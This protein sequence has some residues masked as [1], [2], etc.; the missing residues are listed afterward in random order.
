MA[1]TTYTDV[2]KFIPGNYDSVSKL[3]DAYITSNVIPSADD[4]IN[5]VLGDVYGLFND[6]TDSPATP[7]EI[8]QISN[9]IA[10]ATC[11]QIIGV[12]DALEARRDQYRT[13][14]SERLAALLS[15]GAQMRPQYVTSETLT[16]GDGSPYF[17][18][19]IY[20]AFI[21]AGA[22]NPRLASSGE[23]PNVSA[24]GVAVATATGVTNPG[25]LRNGVDFR[26]YWSNEWRQWVFEALSSDLQSAASSGTVTI[27]YPW[28]YRRMTGFSQPTSTVMILG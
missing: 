20:H 19:P 8:Q 18:L 12:S 3:P 2:K 25:Q 11:L 13:E 26:V 15:R 24:Q 17:E 4:E 21:G 7:P 9:L 16:F 10:A 28:D 1:Y 22:N 23:A 6:T 27:S 5:N 14:A